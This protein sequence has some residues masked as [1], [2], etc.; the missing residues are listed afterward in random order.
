MAQLYGRN[1]HTRGSTS[2]RTRA[3]GHEQDSE[4]QQNQEAEGWSGRAGRAGRAPRIV[5]RG[6]W[7]EFAGGIGV[8]GARL[9]DVGLASAGGTLASAV[10]IADLALAAGTAGRPTRVHSAL[11]TIYDAEFGA[12]A[13]ASVSKCGVL[14]AFEAFGATIEGFDAGWRTGF[15]PAGDSAITLA[16]SVQTGIA[17]NIATALRADRTIVAFAAAP[18]AFESPGTAHSV[19]AT[20]DTPERFAVLAPRATLSAGGA[21]AARRPTVGGLTARL[22]GAVWRAAMMDIREVG[23]G[24][25]L[26]RTAGIDPIVV[27][28]VSAGGRAGLENRAIGATTSRCKARVARLDTRALK[29]QLTRLAGAAIETRLTRTRATRRRSTGSARHTRRVDTIH[30]TPILGLRAVRRRRAA[31]IGFWVLALAVA[32][33]VDG[34]LVGVIA[35]FERARRAEA[36]GAIVRFSASIVVVARAWGWNELAAVVFVAGVGG[37]R[38]VV[39]A[40]QRSPADAAATDANIIGGAGVAVVTRTRHR[41]GDAPGQRITVVLGAWVEVVTFFSHAGRARTEFAL[42]SKGA[43]IPIVTGSG[44]VLVLTPN[45]RGAGVG[46]TRIVIIAGRRYELVAAASDGIARVISANTAIITNGYVWLMR[47]SG[48]RALVQGARNTVAAKR[49]S[50]RVDAAHY[51][52]AGVER[53]LDR[54]DAIEGGPGHAPAFDARIRSGTRIAIFARYT[55]QG[56]ERAPNS[57]LA[58]RLF[59][60]GPCRTH[61]VRR[62]VNTSVIGLA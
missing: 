43:G 62:R 2:L 16:G 50:R 13:A 7:I 1:S 22:V 56:L 60:L 54:I 59:A 12:A 44:G 3:S 28:V 35:R 18:T 37:A 33:L 53:A 24:A 27:G 8:R 32:A 61:I 4:D 34:A 21:L 58:L 26:A 15:A 45:R 48:S 29:A 14:T 46:R 20:L 5:G 40:V 49:V 10:R 23:P 31:V 38:V 55:V 52:V 19:G 47:T 39:V 9:G 25:L 51:G 42:I 36:F 41:H 17:A 30:K 11:V 57:C 6:C